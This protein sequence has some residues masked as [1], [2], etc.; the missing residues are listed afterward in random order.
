M[1]SAVMPTWGPEQYLR[2]EE[3]R[4]RPCRDL[5][6]RIPLD[7]ALSVIDLGC[8]PGNS[9]AVLGELWPRAKITGLDNSTAMLERAHE[10]F[11]QHEWIRGDMAKWAGS[12]GPDYDVVCSNAALQ[13]V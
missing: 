9:T 13:W 8:G 2:F 12:S 10:K 1:L 11:P 4:T 3:E 5:V 7:D 6:G